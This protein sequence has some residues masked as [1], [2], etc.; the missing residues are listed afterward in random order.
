MASINIS[1]PEDLISIL[2][3]EKGSVVTE[4]DPNPP[5]LYVE[6]QNDLDFW[7]ITNLK[8]PVAQ[9]CININGN[10]HTIKNI[11]NNFTDDYHTYLFRLGPGSSVNDLFFSGCNISTLN[12]FCLIKGAD[13]ITNVVIDGTNRFA[14]SGSFKLF[15]TPRSSG[16][17]FN[18]VGVSGTMS[19][20][21]TVAIFSGLITGSN[22]KAYGTARN[23]YVI[24]TITSTNYVYIYNIRYVYN[25]FS[26]SNIKSSW[27]QFV[28]SGNQTPYLYYCY[29][30][31]TMINVKNQYAWGSS[32]SAV[33]V[34]SFYDNERIPN[35]KYPMNGT[36]SANLK[37][38]EW[39]RSQNWAI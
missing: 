39:L 22:P 31:D 24:A 28:S 14:S 30:A 5:I 11:V 2:N 8:E 25:S 4:D 35:A 16:C 21:G 1:T 23:C 32:T 37:S 26:R 18:N 6:I 7:N 38:A 15:H 33:L 29:N 10:G 36:S 19:G 9:V 17:I 13:S 20:V 27:Y 34:Y 3:G 12:E